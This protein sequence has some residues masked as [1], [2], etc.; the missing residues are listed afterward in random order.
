[1]HYKLFNLVGATGYA[2]YAAAHGKWTTFVVGP[3]MLLELVAAII[4]V[5]HW[6]FFTPLVTQREAWAGLVL[7]GIIWLSTALL[8]V[9]QHNILARGFDANAYRLL[10]LTNWLRV[11]AWTARSGLVLLWAARLMR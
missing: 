4:L 2:G 8:Q 9:P 3:P 11:F 10:L 7:V 5:K 6:P 1:V